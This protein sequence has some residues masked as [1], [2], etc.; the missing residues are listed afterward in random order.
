MDQHGP[1]RLQANFAQQ[2]LHGT[3]ADLRA[4]IPL[5]QVALAFG[6]GDDA[7]PPPAALE[8]VH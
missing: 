2:P 1:L 6:T 7:K 3:D 5:S 8:R 4:I